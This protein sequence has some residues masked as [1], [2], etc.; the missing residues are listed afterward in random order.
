MR[1]LA[2]W[3]LFGAALCAGGPEGYLITGPAGSWPLILQPLGQFAATSAKPRIVVANGPITSAQMERSLREGAIVILTG[4]SEAARRLGFAPREPGSRVTVRGVTD[5]AAPELLIAWQDPQAVTVAQLPAAAKLY[6]N[7][8]WSGAPLV[9]GMRR[10]NGAVLWLATEPGAAGYDRYPY[11]PQALADLGLEAPYQARRLWAFFDWS[12]RRRVDLDYF[13]ARWRR[14]GIAALHVAAWHFYDRDPESDAYLKQLIEACHRQQ[15]QVY[16]WLELPHVSERFWAEHPEWREKTAAGQDA[17]LD[18]RKLMSLQQ[19]QCR[20]AI[21]AGLRGLL[22][23]FDWD[24]VNLAE[25]YFESLEGNANL[26]RFTPFHAVVRDRY[27]QETGHEADAKSGDFLEYR[28]RLAEEMQGQWL[29]FVQGLRGDKP[30]LDL[31]LTHVDDRFDKRMRSLI[32]ADAGRVLPLLEQQPFTFLVED[33]ATVWNLGPER[34]EKIAAEYDKLTPHHERLAVDINVVERY[35][36]VY[37][38][39]QQTGTELF[40]LVHQASSSFPR[41]ALYFENSLLKQD[42]A[43]LPTASA[44][45]R[46]WRRVGNKVEV[47]SGSGIDVMWSGGAKVD[48]AWWAATSGWSVMVPAGLHV[49]EPAPSAGLRLLDLNA[50]LIRA[51][52]RHDGLALEYRSTAR[53]WARFNAAVLIDGQDVGCVDAGDCTAA[54]PTGQHQVQVTR[55]AL[56]TQSAVGTTETASPAERP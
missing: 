7:D 48:G 30:D 24:G 11:L 37:P 44:A 20:S 8:R 41:V 45:V 19:P 55:K 17:Q 23:S 36:D 9:A 43:W 13:A 32:G 1:L 25:L 26:A 52:A 56:P 12:Y 51:V 35:Q 50:D 34:Y 14:S 3:L 18:W 47:D 6:T 39:K 33:P 16:A 28:A 29:G 42:L 54:L 27:R 5:V 10:G 49:V 31:V 38:T 21:E 46:A 22:T 15:I 2:S 53:A 40:R 4:D